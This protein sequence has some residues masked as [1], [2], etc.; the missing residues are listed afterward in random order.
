MRAEV[1]SLNLSSA[2]DKTPPPGASRAATHWQWSWRLDGAVGRARTPGD[3]SMSL[4]SSQHPIGSL[5]CACRTTI[6]VWDTGFSFCGCVP[7]SPLSWPLSMSTS[8]LLVICKD[9]VTFTDA[10]SWEPQFCP[11]RR[12][13][14]HMFP[15]WTDSMFT[16]FAIQPWQDCLPSHHP[17]RCGRCS[18]CVCDREGS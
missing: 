9:E 12:L 11:L 14:S 7:D 8:Q 3:L 2:P 5:A 10:L 15:G 16:D 13:C 18:C 6:P 4:V 1:I 17:H